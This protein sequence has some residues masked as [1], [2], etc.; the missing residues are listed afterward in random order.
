MWKAGSHFAAVHMSQAMGLM[1]HSVRHIMMPHAMVSPQHLA[2]PSEI[3]IFIFMQ[4][5]A[6]IAWFG[7]AMHIMPQ[8]C[9]FILSTF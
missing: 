3:I 1:R 9:A 5:P 7:L 2:Q 4:S 8:A 6:H